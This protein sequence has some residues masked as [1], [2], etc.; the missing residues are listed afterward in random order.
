MK[1]LDTRGC[2]GPSHHTVPV[3]AGGGGKWGEHR[4]SRRRNTGPQSCFAFCRF[5]FQGRVCTLLCTFTSTVVNFKVLN[6][7]GLAPLTESLA[8][9]FLP[10][11]VSSNG[12]FFSYL[13]QPTPASVK[14]SD[15]AHRLFF[16]YTDMN[17]NAQG[18]ISKQVWCVHKLS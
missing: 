4:T 14:S 11:S 9:Y 6:I 12:S 8:V 17:T 2:W 3:L 5:S 7:W 13:R 10:Q 15:E 1:S 18:A 16:I